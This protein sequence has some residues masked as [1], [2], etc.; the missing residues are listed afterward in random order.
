[1]GYEFDHNKTK[2]SQNSNRE[3]IYVDVDL[4]SKQQETKDI[5]QCVLAVF[6]GIL[7]FRDNQ[8]QSKAARVKLAER[9]V[10]RVRNLDRIE[11]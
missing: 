10:S 5:E 6:S 3:R 8:M 11:F 1:M 2:N 7:K 9:K 4:C